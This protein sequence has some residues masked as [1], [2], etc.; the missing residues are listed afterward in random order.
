MSYS[1]LDP[2]NVPSHNSKVDPI[3]AQNLAHARGSAGK[4]DAA[5]IDGRR[6]PI[7]GPAVRWPL[8]P[9]W[10]KSPLSR[11]KIRTKVTC[12]A[13]AHAQGSAANFSGI[14]RSRSSAHSRIQ[15]SRAE[16]STLRSAKSCS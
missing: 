7:T 10:A 11:C 16:A 9:L 14:P 1:V 8:S 6:T 3:K 15:S 13:D 12:P 4:T 5:S 2:Q